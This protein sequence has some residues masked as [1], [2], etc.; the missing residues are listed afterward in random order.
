MLTKFS[1]LGWV[2]LFAVGAY[3]VYMVKYEV[4]QL[5]QENIALEKSLQHEKNSLA[6]RRLEWAALN[7]PARLRR[8]SEALLPMEP[9][10][11]DRVV[12]LSA[13]PML[14]KEFANVGA[15]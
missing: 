14:D 1:L 4:E 13:I 9:I 12:E 5:R 7:H 2:M 8:L 11:A 3:G 6:M 10:E 15:R